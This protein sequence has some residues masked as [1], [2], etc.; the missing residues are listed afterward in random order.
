[1]RI[2]SDKAR[3]IAA[4]YLREKDPKLFDWLSVMAATFGKAEEI[5]LDDDEELIRR[6]RDEQSR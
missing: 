1:M 3:K 5:Q 6:L 4:E 2:R